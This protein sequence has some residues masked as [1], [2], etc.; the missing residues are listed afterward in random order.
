MAPHHYAGFRGLV[1]ESL[2]YVATVDDVS[3]AL[4]GVGGGRLDVSSARLMSMIDCSLIMGI[5]LDESGIHS[6]LRH[7]GTVNIKLG[8]VRGRTENEQRSE[9]H[10]VWLVMLYPQTAK[11]FMVPGDNIRMRTRA[12]LRGNICINVVHVLLVVVSERFQD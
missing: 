12:S 6:S 11:V 7:R 8:W 9:L 4:L 10:L 3:V 2:Y 1:C 5:L